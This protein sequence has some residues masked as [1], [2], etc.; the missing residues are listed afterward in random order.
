MT[1]FGLE[2]KI[3]NS[4]CSLM[5]KKFYEILP[6]TCVEKF[7]FG[8][9][10]E[11]FN[12]LKK[13]QWFKLRDIEKLQLKKLKR[14]VWHS[15]TYIPFY[16]RK[17]KEVGITP[18]DIRS[19]D[20]IKKIPI[21]SKHELKR[22]IKK[23]ISP[24]CGFYRI[25]STSGSTG[26]PLKG[27]I[28]LEGCKWR[29]AAL[30]LVFSWSGFN[31]EVD[32]IMGIGIPPSQGASMNIKYITNRFFN[33]LFSNRLI[34]HPQKLNSKEFAKIFFII[35]KFEPKLIRSYPYLLNFLAKFQK[36]IDTKFPNSLEYIYLTGE[37]F[38]K[39][40]IEKFSGVEVFN[41][42]GS[43]VESGPIAGECKEHSGMH[44]HMENHILELVKNGEVLSE[45]EKGDVIITDFTNF[46]MPLIRYNM[47]DMSEIEKG[48]CSCGRELTRLTQ[49]FGRK[50]DIL[51]SSSGEFINANDGI[52]PA[53]DEFDNFY[54]AVDQYRVIQ[55]KINSIKVL[56]VPTDE[57]SE[58]IEKIIISRIK[59]LLGEET[60][61]KIKLVNKIP[62]GN[63]F[64]HVISKVSKKFFNKL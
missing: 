29:D 36:K 12:F 40:V 8:L 63:K 11:E 62:H 19:L 32:K 53:M 15:Y 5:P 47:E 44:I 18:Y 28:S 10:R 61:V 34:W 56:I 54:N 21:L 4:I 45:M 51:I 55:D 33:Y 38:N 26:K 13:S 46:D 17:F 60:E 6:Q 24:N 37:A 27:P 1:K 31:P 30:Q 57:F 22:N 16:R 20:D 39:E 58:K 35:S 50:A 14:I 3:T 9:I 7:R 23:I 43:N 64:R 59:K 52:F 42:Y 48:R 25:N 2:Y 41:Q 49:V